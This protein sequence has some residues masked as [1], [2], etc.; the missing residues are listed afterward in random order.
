MADGVLSL[1]VCAPEAAPVTLE[2]SEVVIPG[3]SGVFTVYP[4]HTPLLSTLIPGVLVTTDLAGEQRFFAVH[5][6][7]AE[8]REN[9]VRILADDFESQDNIDLPRAQAAE[10][11]AE[12]RLRKPVEDMNWDRAEVAL[13]RATARIGAS[14]KRGYN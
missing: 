14:S 5:G 3:E 1:E 4:G 6:G 2:V 9:C 13:A 12:G 11:R 7:F 8:V 10:Q